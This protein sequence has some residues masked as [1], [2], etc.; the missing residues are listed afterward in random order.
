VSRLSRFSS[1]RTVLALW[2]VAAVIAASLTAV[3]LLRDA[4]GEDVSAYIE[5]VNASQQSFAVRYGSVDRAYREFT[6]APDAMEEQLP[7]LREAAR[8]MTAVRVR[9]AAV[10]APREATELR[11]RLLAFLRQQ[12]LVANELVDVAVYLPK[13]AATERPVATASSRLRGELER[14]ATPEAQADAFGRYGATLSRT[15]QS[16]DRLQPPPLLTPAHRAYTRQ[17][18]EYAQSA[19]AL[20]RGVRSADQEAVDSAVRRLEAA[21]T[22]GSQKAQRDAIKAYNVRVQTIRKLGVELEEERQRLERELA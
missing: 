22:S 15:T 8:T 21:S 19:Q 17:L 6:L 1:R 9:I 10:E 13:L 16:L 18:R 3:L 4:P 12:E 5:E 14:A 2:A 7:R 11:K 20:Q